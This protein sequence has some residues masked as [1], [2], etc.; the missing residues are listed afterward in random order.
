M[1]CP[2]GR[3]GVRWP[4]RGRLAMSL[5]RRKP[6]RTPALG[7]KN[8]VRWPDGQRGQWHSPPLTV[9]KLGPPETVPTLPGC[10]RGGL[11]GNVACCPQPSPSGCSPAPRHLRT[12][13]AYELPPLACSGRPTG[14]RR[15][16]AASAWGQSNH[17]APST[18]TRT[19]PAFLH[20][21]S[22]DCPRTIRVGPWTDRRTAALHDCTHP[23]SPALHCIALHCTAFHATM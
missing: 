12:I 8:R 23:A 3:W 19:A 13:R 7:Q 5:R 9:C 10:H 15:G 1:P 4:N 21:L 14:Q 17:R 18:L 16:A 6:L 11:V 2:R 22:C 20:Q